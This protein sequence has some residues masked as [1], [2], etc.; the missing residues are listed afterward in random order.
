MTAIVL[1]EINRVEP[2]WYT[3]KNGIEITKLVVSNLPLEA[4]ANFN[5]Y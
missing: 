3:K 2:H 5:I 1:D 4:S